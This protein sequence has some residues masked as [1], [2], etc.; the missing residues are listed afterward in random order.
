VFTLQQDVDVEVQF[1]F[2]LKR[3]PSVHELSV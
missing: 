1:V 3:W 2:R